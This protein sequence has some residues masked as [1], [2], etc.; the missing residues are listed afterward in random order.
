[1]AAA[2]ARARGFTLLELLVVLVII[3]LASTLVFVS[4]TG[5][6]FRSRESRF[7]E[8]F[9]SYLV[10]AKAAALGGGRM[11]EFLIDGEERRFGLDGRGWR[12]I[13]K[14]MQIEAEGL[15]DEGNSTYGLVFYPDGSSSGGAIDLVWDDGRRDQFQVTRLLGRIVHG[16]KGP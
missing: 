1:M 15:L 5:S 12:P 4:T 13:P 16:V 2:A 7:V 6:L 9:Q 10:R 14:T 11:V 3:G 8:E